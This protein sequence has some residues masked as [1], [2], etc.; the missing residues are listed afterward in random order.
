VAYVSEDDFRSTVQIIRDLLESGALRLLLNPSFGADA[1]VRFVF[2][3]EQAEVDQLLSGRGTTESAFEAAAD[4]IAATLSA[5]V[6]E[7]PPDRF[8]QQRADPERTDGDP[9]DPDVAR[10]KLQLVSESFDIASLQQRWWVKRTA[11]TRVFSALRWNVANRLADDEASPPEGGGAPFGILMLEGATAATTPL[12]LFSNPVT[13]LTLVVD[14][15]DVVAMRD[16][17]DR[18]ISALD[19]HSPRREAQDG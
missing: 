8:S 11:K 16:T 10:R 15:E 1:P 9:E 14:K 6:R 5:A 3:Q 13:D 17:L 4:D 18:L 19:A 2:R 12:S 7:T